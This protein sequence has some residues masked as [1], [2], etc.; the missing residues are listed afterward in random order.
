MRTPVRSTSSLVVASLGWISS[1]VDMPPT[2]KTT[3]PTRPRVKGAAAKAAPL[4]AAHR[5]SRRK[6][7]TRAKLL[8]AALH[9]MA[10]RGVAGV[11]INEITQQADVGF[12]SFYNHFESKE[13]IYATLIE[14]VISQYAV[15]LDKLGDQLPDPA[16][17]I[18]ASARYTMLRGHEDPTWGRFVFQTNFSRESMT[19][20]LGRYL[21]QDIGNGIA[22]GRLTV[23]DLPSVYIAV[24]STILGGLAA[25][26]DQSH[27]GTEPDM[28]E[29]A[30]TLTERLAAIILTILGLSKEE[31]QKVATRPLPKI[32]LPSNPFAAV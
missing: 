24:G 20:G 4:E 22:A 31:A 32:E 7:D 26:S 13:A 29:D 19:S 21:L 28:F 5:G 6:R 1:T 2:K 25:L 8:S 23:G 3:S 30:K 27:V 12:G 15:A 10:H 18:A 17:K 16:E 14:E 11:A 9:L